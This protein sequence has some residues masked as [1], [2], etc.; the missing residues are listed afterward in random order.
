MSRLQPRLTTASGSQPGGTER[1]INGQLNY[2]SVS[3]F[4]PHFLTRVPLKMVR[5]AGLAGAESIS[6]LAS[7][8]P[9]REARRGQLLVTSYTDLR[10]SQTRVNTLGKEYQALSAVISNVNINI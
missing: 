5:R 10:H 8:S 7:Q 9:A 2:N 3:R 6:S 4:T 1:N